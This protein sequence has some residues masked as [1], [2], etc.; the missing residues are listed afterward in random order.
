M[1]FTGLKSFDFVFATQKFLIIVV[2]KVD[3]VSI[4]SLTESYLFTRGP[5]LKNM[6]R[7]NVVRVL[8]EC[9]RSS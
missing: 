8:I 2:I 7:T 4:F 1:D 9:Y 5:I 6:V 3:H